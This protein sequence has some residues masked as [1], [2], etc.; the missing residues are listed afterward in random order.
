MNLIF[1]DNI[2]NLWRQYLHIFIQIETIIVRYVSS[3]P[4]YIW[5]FL[6]DKSLIRWYDA[7]FGKLFFGNVC[8]Y[9]QSYQ[10]ET[11]F[12]MYF[13]VKLSLFK[14]NSIISIYI[15]IWFSIHRFFHVLV[16]IRFQVLFV[17][18]IN[19]KKRLL[20]MFI[21]QW[22][23]NLWLTYS[24]YEHFEIFMCRKLLRFADLNFLRQKK[25]LE[26]WI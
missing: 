16:H 21:D 5:F 18:S 14:Q 26:L 17:G 24:K 3:L 13:F 12:S 23:E 20:E 6:F 10:K 1:V 4:N 19:A 9:P 2:G 7:V 25:N 11:K 15:S 22:N 8:F